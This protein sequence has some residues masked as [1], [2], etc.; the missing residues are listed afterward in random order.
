MDFYSRF[1]WAVPTVFSDAIA[2]CKFEEGDILYDSQ[3][4]YQEW[5]KA[6]ESIRYYIKVKSPKRTLR[7]TKGKN[8]TVVLANWD[9]EVKIELKSF[10]NNSPAKLIKTTQGKLFTLLWKGNLEI[11]NDDMPNPSPPL[12]L[13]DVKKQIKGKV[14]KNLFENKVIEC[15]RIA[16]NKYYFIF[17]CD[18][19]NSNSLEHHLNVLSALKE[20]YG[21]QFFRLTPKESGFKEW[22]KI[23]PVIDTHLYA[24]EKGAYADIDETLKRELYRP[25]KGSKTDRFRLS[26]HGILGPEK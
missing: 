10:F 25:L 11:L 14:E 23:S 20:E 2:N 4:A 3:F 1:S 26:A 17:V 12:L 19:T 18:P 24:I 15:S 16:K 6:K 5:G 21:C 22:E 9:S 8:K 7:V 13:K